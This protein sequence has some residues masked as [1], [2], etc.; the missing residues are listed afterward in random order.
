M[1]PTPVQF[2]Q[3]PEGSERETAR[4][5]TRA[6]NDTIGGGFDAV[7][8]AREKDERGEAPCDGVSS[9]ECIVASVYSQSTG[10]HSELYQAWECPECGSVH[11]GFTSAM[12]CCC[13]VQ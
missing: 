2:D 8:L 3:L 7:I 12:S 1:R 11:V 4:V 6:T 13:D 10:R 5:A 9:F